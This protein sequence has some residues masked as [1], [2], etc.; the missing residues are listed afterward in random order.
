MGKRIN[1]DN[2]TSS[3]RERR[4]GRLFLV[5]VSAAAL[6][7]AD[8]TVKASIGT[9]SSYL[10]QRSWVWVGLSALLLVGALALA[11]VPSSAVALAA[12][13][14]SGGVL[15]NLVSARLDGNRVPN[16]FLIDGYGNNVAFN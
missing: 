4:S 3:V 2:M 16:P 14:T 9:G 8:L 13:V 6:T 1:N 11:L 5:V 12:G 15:G 10:H 7:A